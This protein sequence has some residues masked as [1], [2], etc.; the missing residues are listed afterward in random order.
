MARNGESSLIT[1]VYTL[2]PQHFFKNHLIV[3]AALIHLHDLDYEHF[4]FCFIKI[5]VIWKE[6][7][8]SYLS[9][10]LHWHYVS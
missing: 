7:K 9:C 5:A 4:V 10:I 8:C 1:L 2:K 6:F 3:I